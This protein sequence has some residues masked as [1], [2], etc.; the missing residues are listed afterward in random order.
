MNLSEG[1]SRATTTKDPY[2][3]AECEDN[4][5]W[6]P[7]PSQTVPDHTYVGFGFVDQPELDIESDVRW[8]EISA[9]VKYQARHHDSQAGINVPVRFT[10]VLIIYTLG[11]MTQ[12]RE[13]RGIKILFNVKNVIRYKK[14]SENTKTNL[15]KDWGRLKREN[16]TFGKAERK[17]K[18]QVEES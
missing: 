14:E 4:A 8:K 2:I 3:N 12:L 10:C 5:E 7:L 15:K 18:R 9:L 1:P 11:C 6:M 17:I 13:L 16:K